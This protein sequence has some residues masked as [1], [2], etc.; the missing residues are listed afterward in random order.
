MIPLLLD[1]LPILALYGA[2]C[3]VGNVLA[4]CCGPKC[5]DACQ[6]G[7][8]PKSVQVVLANMADGTC[9]G[10][11]SCPSLD[12]TFVL[13]LVSNN[14]GVC[15][16]EVA[17]PFND[18]GFTFLR[19]QFS[20][21]GILSADAYVVVYLDN[22]STHAWLYESGSTAP[23]DCSSFNNLSVPIF[24]SPSICTAAGTAT[25]TSL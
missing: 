3:L 21:P 12:G 16:Y 10:I 19:V 8:A 18:C 7:T 24:G 14:D 4:C 5:K 17:L 22:T 20:E 1:W 6:N 25:V 2:H 13:P 15:F 11:D 9:S 23:M